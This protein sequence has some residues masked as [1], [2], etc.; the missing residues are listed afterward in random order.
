[1]SNITNN[2]SLRLCPNCGSELPASGWEGLC[3]KCLYSYRCEACQGRSAEVSF[4]ATA[5]DIVEAG[6]AAFPDSVGAAPFHL[7][8]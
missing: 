4:P 2:V 7:T 6:P 3:P 1:M 8:A 5:R